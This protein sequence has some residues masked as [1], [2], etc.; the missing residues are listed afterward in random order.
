[1]KSIELTHTHITNDGGLEKAAIRDK[2]KGKERE[3]ESV[4]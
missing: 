1:M 4:H 2:T 3:D